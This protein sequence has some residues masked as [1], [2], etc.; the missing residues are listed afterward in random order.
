MKEI[1][2]TQGKVALIDDADFE[3]VSKYK[4]HAHFDGYNWYARTNPIQEGKRSLLLMHRL[5]LGLERGDKRQGEHIHHNGLDNRRKEIRI[6]NHQQNHFN[7]KSNKNTTS[8]FKGVHW[9]SKIGKWIAQFKKKKSV[10]Y[11]GCWELEEVAALAYDIAAT[12]EFGEFANC[13]FN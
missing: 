4:W 13:N 2:L 11:L 9:H 7:R 5:I 6:C 3:L 10:H 12:R 1:K 8:H